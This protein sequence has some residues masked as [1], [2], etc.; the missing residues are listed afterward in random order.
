MNG[1][2]H[3]VTGSIVWGN[4][5]LDFCMTLGSLLSLP[6]VC[7]A[8]R[9]QKRTSDPLELRLLTVRRH[10][11]DA[12]PWTPLFWV[13]H[14]HCHHY[15]LIPFPSDPHYSTLL[16]PATL[17]AA[18]NSYKSIAPSPKSVKKMSEVPDH[19]RACV[20]LSPNVWH[21]LLSRLWRNPYCL[22]ALLFPC[23]YR[24]L[25]VLHRPARKS[26]PPRSLPRSAF[27]ITPVWCGCSLSV[28]WKSV[29]FLEC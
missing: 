26:A 17:T 22:N 19:L 28:T 29:A 16:N 2:C 7:R 5:N 24:T 21:F 23:T 10:H 8:H 25:L 15:L 3:H 20:A 18:S 1:A 27:P 13:I 12:G 11:I 4:P 14:Q 9:S 6:H